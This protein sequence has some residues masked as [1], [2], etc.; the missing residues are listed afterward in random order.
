ML[1]DNLICQTFRTKDLK[2]DFL[3]APRELIERVANQW[4]TTPAKIEGV[5][6]HQNRYKDA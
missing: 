5:L 2:L 6:K 4:E 3:D 1:L